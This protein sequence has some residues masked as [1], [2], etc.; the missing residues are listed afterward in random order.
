[1]GTG[2]RIL[3]VRGHGYGSFVACTS[4]LDSNPTQNST[5]TDLNCIAINSNDEAFT[6]SD[7]CNDG[8]VR[9]CNPVFLSIQSTTA[10]TIRRCSGE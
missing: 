9:D 6:F 2:N 7:I 4:R 8:L 5:A 1:M 3:R 10:N